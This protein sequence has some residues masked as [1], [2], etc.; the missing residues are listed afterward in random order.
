MVVVAVAI[1]P[2]FVRSPYY[3]DLIVQV[4]LW[5]AAASAWNIV[6]GYGGQLS[7]GHA[8]FF[9]IGAYTS[10]LLFLNAG[11]SPWIGMFAGALLATAAGLVL[12]TLTLRLRGPFFALLTLAFGQVLLIF[13]THWRSVTQGSNG[14]SLPFQADASNFLFSGTTPYL[15]AMLLLAASYYL[16]S[17]ALERHRVGYFLVALREN[18][19]AARALGVRAT[20]LRLLALC[21]S[22]A[23]TAICG[24]F[25]AQYIRFIDPASVT[26]IDISLRVALIAI[27]GGIGTAGGPFVGAVVVI[28][29]TDY[30]RGSTSAE[31]GGSYLAIYGLVLM[32]VVL[33]APNGIISLIRKIL[34][35]IKRRRWT[36]AEGQA[37]ENG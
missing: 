22:A 25:Y 26:G 4:L 18:D 28:L 37:V 7:L 1:I 9:A 10:T 34:R 15:Y 29:L 16:L 36:R 20:R 31:L 23:L 12:G 30:L 6:G 5:G 2:L 3:L 8:G 17:F 13:T 19:N 32:I 27:L 35:F 24:T 21:L 14:L 33:L 11:V